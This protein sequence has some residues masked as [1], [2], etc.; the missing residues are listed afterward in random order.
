MFYIPAF[1]LSHGLS[2][3]C[4]VVWCLGGG[5]G[6]WPHQKHS[7][8][9]SNWLLLAEI[10]AAVLNRG[11][12]KDL[13][14]PEFKQTYCWLKRYNYFPFASS[15]HPVSLHRV[16]FNRATATVAAS[17][18]RSPCLPPPPRSNLFFPRP[19]GLWVLLF[20]SLPL[21]LVWVGNWSR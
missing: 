15:Y 2:G 21:S 18:T 17:L 10:I 11:E 20:P 3:F 19:R 12:L 14:I 6:P 7:P 4:K 13:F 1:S 9:P 5:G 16:S 8:P